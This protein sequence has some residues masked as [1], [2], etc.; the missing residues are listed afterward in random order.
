M[1]QSDFLYDR[2]GKGYRDYRRADPHIMAA[3]VDVLSDCETVLNVGAGTGSYEP[4]DRQV[5]AVEPSETMIR[6]RRADGAPVVRA[7]AKNLPFADGTFDAALALLTIHHWPDQMRGLREMVRVAKQRIVLTHDHSNA[8]M[9]LTQ[10]YFPEIVEQGK[11]IFPP[12]EFCRE[13]LG[14]TSITTIPIPHDCTDGFLQ[15][16]WRRPEA[17]FDPGVRG[18]ISSFAQ[19]QNV[20]L[21][22][23]RLRRDLDDGTWHKR[24]GH[25]LAEKELDLGYRLVVSIGP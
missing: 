14:K 13:A 16:Y 19:V 4:N 24:Y 17:Y 6:Q 1:V 3:I 22:L 21:G 7:C 25:L 18:A 9:W 12:V 15:A 2:I 20:E 23:S 5:V 11:A 10:D 8:G